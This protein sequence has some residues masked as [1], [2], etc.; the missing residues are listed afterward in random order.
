[1]HVPILLDVPIT[2]EVGDGTTHAPMI[3]VRVGEV[4]TKLILDTGSTDQ[5]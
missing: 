2:F 4:A 3:D 1:M 5:S